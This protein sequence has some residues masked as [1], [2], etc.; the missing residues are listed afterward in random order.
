MDDFYWIHFYFVIYFTIIFKINA[1]SSVYGIQTK[2]ISGALNIEELNLALSNKCLNE[3]YRYGEFSSEF[4]T[5]GSELSRV[6]NDI[7][8][9]I[10]YIE[11]FDEYLS[12]EEVVL[13]H[14]MDHQLDLIS[15]DS[16]AEHLGL[17]PVNPTMACYSNIIYDLYKLFVELQKYIIVRNTMMI[18]L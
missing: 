13:F 14:K 3:S 6:C 17:R 18:P 1:F 8:K 9:Y 11:R 15:Y 7:K 5:I 4:I 10:R 16:L 2:I 12:S